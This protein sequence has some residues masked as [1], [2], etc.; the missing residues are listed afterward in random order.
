[1]STLVRFGPDE[2]LVG[3]LSGSATAKGPILVLPSAGLVPRTGPFRLHVE[4]AER[5]ASQGMRT[6]RFDAPGVGEA[7]RIPGMADVEAT[8]AALD[9]LA[10]HHGGERFVVGGICAAADVGWR[11]AVDDERVVAMLML[12]GLA[13]SGPWFHLARIT[14]AFRRGPSSWLGI[15]KRIFG[16]AGGGLDRR[17]EIADYREWPSPTQARAEFAGLVRNGK[18][19]LWIY[20]GG[21]VDVF[22]HPRQFDWSFG[23]SSSASCVEMEFWPDCDHT[24][25]A[26][27]HRMRLLDRI[28]RWLLSMEPTGP[29][30]LEQR[31]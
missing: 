22:L 5:L 14:N 3:V 8:L 29:A 18:R 17:F 13:F 25:F 4:L 16:R 20:T 24:F 12:D 2:R 26:T 19:S 10:L 11:A 9:H 21:Y 30:A 27:P 7:P 15:A 23:A 1:M 28:E 31:A 6:F